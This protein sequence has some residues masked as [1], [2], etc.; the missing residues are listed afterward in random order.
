M[1][2]GWQSGDKYIVYHR[3]SGEQAA[4]QKVYVVTK[5]MFVFL[6]YLFSEKR[7]WPVNNEVMQAVACAG[8][9]AVLHFFNIKS[10]RAR[11]S[12]M[13][14]MRSKSACSDLALL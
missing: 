4:Y 7:L 11:R 3:G 8:Y 9:L 13:H 2:L 10:R 14:W 12:A 1:Y 6:G 5:P